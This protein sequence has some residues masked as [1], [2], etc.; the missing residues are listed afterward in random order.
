MNDLN[1]HSNLVAGYGN[2][3]SGSGNLVSGQGNF[4]VGDDASE[5]EKRKVK[6]QLM[7]M[8]SQRGLIGGIGS[9]ASNSLSQT[10]SQKQ[11]SKQQ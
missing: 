2:K 3:I 6:E 11:E 9:S 10:T 7:S 4:V 8:F 1:G 5:E